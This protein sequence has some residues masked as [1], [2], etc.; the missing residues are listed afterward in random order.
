MRGIKMEDEKKD[1]VEKALR[2]EAREKSWIAGMYAREEIEAKRQRIKEEGLN[3]DEY[4]PYYA[5]Y[6][7]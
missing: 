4:H 6:D 1:K 7:N 3:E 5:K 2:R